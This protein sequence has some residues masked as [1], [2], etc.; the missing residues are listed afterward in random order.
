MENYAAFEPGDKAPSFAPVDDEGL[1]AWLLDSRAQAE[2]HETPNIEQLRMPRRRERG[3]S[4]WSV[5]DFQITGDNPVPVR[6]YQNDRTPRPL[7]VYVHGGGFVFG[8]LQSHD[9]TCRR[10]ALHANVNVLAVD[11]RRAP[12]FPAPAAIDDVL[13]VLRWTTEPPQSLAGQPLALAGDS[14]GG[15][16]ALLA[17]NEFVATGGQLAAQMLVCPNA[18]LTMEQPSIQMKSTGW[19][20]SISDLRWFIRQWVHD[21][22]PA[23]LRKFSPLHVNLKALP[24]TLIATA[25]H[26]PLHDEGVALV[27]K[28]NRIGVDVRLIDHAGLVHG[29]LSLDTV[30]TSAE[31]AGT[32]LFQLFGQL[33][34]DRASE[35]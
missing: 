5:N 4:L 11:Y 25:E 23:T 10:L 2:K 14:A 26:D 33:L 35:L 6:L 9:R 21:L 13:D 29:F 17:A 8:D 16:I 32:K 28:L 20:L 27:Q 7:V 34:D 31:M 22:E 3:P 12:E 1:E 30:S 19:G 15:M 24:T 18:D